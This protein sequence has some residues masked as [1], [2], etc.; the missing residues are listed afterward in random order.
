MLDNKNKAGK[1]IQQKETVSKNI[2]QALKFF[3]W[4]FVIHF[5]MQI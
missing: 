1:Q 5:F 4:L 2:S 3:I